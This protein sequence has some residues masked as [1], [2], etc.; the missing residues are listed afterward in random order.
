MVIIIRDPLYHSYTIVIICYNY[1]N[2]YPLCHYV[3]AIN[4]LIRG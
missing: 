2:M 3:I 1:T 4:I